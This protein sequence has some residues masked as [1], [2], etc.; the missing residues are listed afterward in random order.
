MIIFTSHQKQ[1]V[2]YK[3]KM[4]ETKICLKQKCSKINKKHMVFWSKLTQKTES[5]ESQ[6]KWLL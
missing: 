5:L 1:I 3:Q 2:F 4:F 6:I